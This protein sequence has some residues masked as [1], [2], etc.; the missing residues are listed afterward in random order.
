MNTGDPT[1]APD[2]S[3]VVV[4]SFATWEYGCCGGTPEVGGPL[5]GSLCATEPDPAADERFLGPPVDGWDRARRIARFGP[6]SARWAADTDPRGRRLAL[7]LTRHDAEPAPEIRGTVVGL[8]RVSAL[9]RFNGEYW[10]PTPGST[11]YRRVRELGWSPEEPGSLSDPA[12]EYRRETGVLIGL[13]VEETDEPTAEVVAEYLA[14]EDRESRTI[15]LTGPAEVF[16]ET[17][18]SEGARLAVDLADPRLEVSGPGAE[19]RTTV[20]GTVVQV[21]A[22]YDSGDGFWRFIDVPPGTRAGDM[23][24]P[25]L[26]R[27]EIDADRFG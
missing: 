15:R 6:M 5:S 8:Y 1:P 14:R 13:A 21:S 9:F 17:V 20:P 12:A 19:L 26:I 3:A 23:E 4:V 16:G 24:R 27:L 7:Y 25:L 18:P 22:E 10:A 11:E 2:S